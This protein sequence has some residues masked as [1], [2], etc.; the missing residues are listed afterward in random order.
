MAECDHGVAVL[1]GRCVPY[2]EANVWWPV[3]EALRS[4][5]E[6]K[7]RP[8]RVDVARVAR[9]E[10]RTKAGLPMDSAAEIERVTDGLLHLMGYEGP[11]D[12]I[13][14]ARAREE[15][16]R[17]LLTFIDGFARQQPV[18]VLLSDLHWA[19][20]LVL[21]LVDQLLERLSALPVVLIGTAR[22]DLFERWKPAVGR[23]NQLVLNLDPLSREATASLLEAI[24]EGPVPD[25]LRNALLDRSGGN[26]FFLEELVPFWPRRS[27]ATTKVPL[28]PAGPAASCRTRCA[29]SSRRGSMVSRSTSAAR[30]KT[31]PCSAAAAR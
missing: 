25:D 28:P 16:R 11:L 26:P 10:A 24:A 13:D 14:P 30:S 9:C 8:I 29:A 2:G 23:H 19:D 6:V 12:G 3:A 27:C 5:C 1:E 17:S 20:D 22:T 15:V 18:V 31:R 7:R 4:T 21:D